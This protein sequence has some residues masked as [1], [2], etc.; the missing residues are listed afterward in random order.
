MITVLIQTLWNL[1]LFLLALGLV[2]IAIFVL[3][4]L[5][6]GVWKAINK[7]VQKDGRNKRN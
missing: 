4:A 3:S 2:I 6:V 7:E 5:V 1:F